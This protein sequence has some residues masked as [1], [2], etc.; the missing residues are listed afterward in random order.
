MSKRKITVEQEQEICKKYYTNSSSELAKAYGCSDTNI[1]KVWRVNGL[2]GKS[3][4]QY[5][6][7]FNY[8][9]NIDAEDKAYFLGFIASDGC[10]YSGYD[11]QQGMIKVTIHSKDIDVLTKMKSYMKATNNIREIGK[12]NQVELKISSDKL[13][14]DLQKLGVVERKSLTYTPIEIDDKLMRH[15]LRGFFDGDGTI[16]CEK[17]SKPHIPS[18]YAVGITCNKNTALFISNHLRT[19][20]INVQQIKYEKR[21]DNKGKNTYDLRIYTILD[22]Y[23]FLN[24][25]YSDATVYMDRKYAMYLLY[26]QVFEENRR[27]LKTINKELGDNA[28]NS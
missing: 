18:S 14:R 23:N 24:Y 20:D 25:L 11:N 16:H 26:K 8:F 7:D 13:F 28:R 27:P 10:V 3:N 2:K 4:R 12:H 19:K 17:K 6:C 1:R 9:E 15:F 22:M 5:Y 21:S